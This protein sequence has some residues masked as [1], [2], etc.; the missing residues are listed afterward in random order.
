[1]VLQVPSGVR[2]EISKGWIYGPLRKKIGQIMRELCCQA[3]I[4]L[5][6]GY[7]IPDH[8]HLYL[9]IPPKFSVANTVV[10]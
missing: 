5:V 6:E 1:M 4:E 8:L 2:T 3:Q 10:F 9:S 7:A